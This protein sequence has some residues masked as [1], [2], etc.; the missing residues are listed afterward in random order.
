L[1]E[2]EAKIVVFTEPWLDTLGFCAATRGID[3]HSCLRLCSLSFSLL[4]PLFQKPE[5]LRFDRTSSSE[6]IRGFF[7]SL[8]G[9]L[10]FLS[11]PSSIDQWVANTIGVP[12][13]KPDS[14]WEAEIIRNIPGARELG[15]WKATLSGNQLRIAT[16]VIGQFDDMLSGVTNS[17]I[18]WPRDVFVFGHEAGNFVTGPI[19]MVGRA[20][21]LCFGPYLHLPRGNWRIDVNFT[22]KGNCAGNSIQLDV[23]DGSVLAKGHASLPSSGHFSTFLE[24]FVHEARRPLEV[25]VLMEYG[26]IDGV[27]NLI[28]VGITPAVS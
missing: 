9:Y 12:T 1:Y 22:I 19:D 23:F 7:N 4:L 3:F 24:F 20:R 14:D 25:R 28:E 17:R 13:F 15:A 18:A 8:V 27:F 16:D 2:H 6:S 21:Y 10:G 26:A 11:E 5:F